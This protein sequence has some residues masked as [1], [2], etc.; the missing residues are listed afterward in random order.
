MYYM[1]TQEHT[2][3]VRVPI[4]VAAELKRRA[5]SN[6]CSMSDIARDLIMTGLVGP[7]IEHIFLSRVTWGKAVKE[8]D[9]YKCVQ[10]G[11]EHDVEAHHIKPVYQGGQNVLSNGET[12]CPKCHAK[13]HQSDTH[14]F[15]SEDI[16]TSIPRCWLLRRQGVRNVRGGDDS[17]FW[18]EQL[19]CFLTKRKKAKSSVVQ[20]YVDQYLADVPE[21]VV[22]RTLL[23]LCP[24]PRTISEFPA[25]SYATPNEH[26]EPPP[27]IWE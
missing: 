13:Q 23:A 11:S 9:G 22:I 19:A 2:I 20:R 7:V 10:C 14:L 18:R 6:H 3:T 16:Q 25:R 12:L 4:E 8:R 26:F 21:D 27:L 24:T 1:R 5:T 15:S 17:R